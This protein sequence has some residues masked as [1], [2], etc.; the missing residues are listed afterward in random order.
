MMEA[1][2][3]VLASGLLHVEHTHSLFLHLLLSEGAVGLILFLFISMRALIFGKNLGARSAFLSLLL[4]GI[5]DDPLYSGQ[6]EV[7]FWLTL[8]LC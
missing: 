8:G 4:F 1:L 6:T 5:F 2:S 7:L 3:P